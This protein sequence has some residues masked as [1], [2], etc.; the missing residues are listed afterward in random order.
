MRRFQITG[1][2]FSVH[3]QLKPVEEAAKAYEEAL[4]RG[5][6]SAL[7]REY[8]DG[9]VN[10]SVG[11]LRKDEAV[12]VWLKIVAGV[13]LNDGGLR[14]RFPF[15]LAPSSQPNARMSAVEGGGEIELPEEEF[16]DLVLPA[17]SAVQD[18][19]ERR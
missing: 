7:A 3:S 5:H 6:L 18:N 13:E 19:P 15:T 12:T 16:G 14:F 10:L 11:N 1:E 8:R 9:L 4:A 17:F 2:G